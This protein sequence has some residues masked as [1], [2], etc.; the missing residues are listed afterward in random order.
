MTAGE[1][2][3]IFEMFSIKPDEKKVFEYMHKYLWK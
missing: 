3:A 1:A 2:A